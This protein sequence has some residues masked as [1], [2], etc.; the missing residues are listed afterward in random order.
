MAIEAGPRTDW[1]SAGRPWRHEGTGSVR[2][3]SERSGQP[4]QCSQ[5]EGGALG[6][7]GGGEYPTMWRSAGRAQGTYDLV[8]S[9]RS[10]RATARGRP[11]RECVDDE[12]RPRGRRFHAVSRQKLFRTYQFGELR[13]N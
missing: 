12:T 2:I 1:V 7:C 8:D 4:G 5:P 9:T 11:T 6:R 10:A 3:N 13:V